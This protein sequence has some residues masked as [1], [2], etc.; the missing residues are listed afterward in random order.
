MECA[1]SCALA[2]NSFRAQL[3]E[4]EHVGE[5]DKR[6][7]LASFGVGQFTDLILPVEE[8]LQS[9]AKR[10]GHPEIAPITRNIEF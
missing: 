8:L 10:L 3:H 7:C 5:F 2:S 1:R 9:I 6:F 4:R